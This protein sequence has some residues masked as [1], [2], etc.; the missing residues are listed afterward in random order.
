MENETESPETD[1]EQA[2][3]HE[4]DPIIEIEP[5]KPEEPME[6]LYQIWLAPECKSVRPT[7]HEPSFLYI[8]ASS[9]SEAALKSAL[10]ADRTRG[11]R[12][13]CQVQAR[14]RELYV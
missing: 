6:R 10:I 14:E 7:P 8:R 13:P 12:C 4:D 1:E 2:P 9:E 3:S 11:I 5:P